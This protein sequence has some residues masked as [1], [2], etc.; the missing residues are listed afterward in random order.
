MATYQMQAPDGHTY[1]IDGPDGATDDQVRAEII[2]QNP[3]LGEPA[4]PPAAA[5]AQPKTPQQV[6]PQGTFASYA[7]KSSMFPQNQIPAGPVNIG[8]NLAATAQTGAHLATAGLASLGGGL[9]YLGTLAATQ[10]PSA[11][12]SVMQSTQNSLTYNPQNQISQQQLSGI[13]QG[14]AIPDR[15]GGSLGDK[16][17]EA[18]GSPF[19]ATT[20]RILPD[21]LAAFGPG[22]VAGAVGDATAGIAARALQNYRP[23]FTRTPEAQA[24]L[25]QGVDL[26]A[27]QMN[28][29]GVI[30]KLEQGAQRIP[31][32]GNIITSAR[33][34]ALQSF[35]RMI[36]QKAA[37]PGTTI[38]PADVNSMLD[39]AY[40]SYAPLY[41]KAKGIPVQPAIVSGNSSVPLA[42]AFASAAQDASIKAADSNRA[43]VGSWLQNKLTSLQTNPN[44]PMALDSAQLIDLRSDIRAQ[45]RKDSMSA[46]AGKNDEADLLRGA[47]NAITRSLE[48][49]LPPDALAALKTADQNYG[50]YKVI[51]KAVIKAKDNPNGFTPENLSQAIKESTS[52]GVYARG[53]GRFRSDAQAAK[54]SISPN[55]PVT[56]AILATIGVPAAA[57][58]A[59]PAVGAAAVGGALA[60]T[61]TQFGRNWA[62]GKT[63]VQLS[64][65]NLAQ[66]L[67]KRR[68]ATDIFNLGSG[69]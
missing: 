57:I 11:A 9:N 34:N 25:D 60:L 21:A 51:E 47:E 3:H 68:D 17:L 39:E 28:P 5:T 29:T 24:L 31:I 48:S 32:V 36:T 18:T 41:D 43:S 19:L 42:Q 1:T 55:E 49:Q 13:N 58:L 35:Q 7:P 52:P 40:Q 46:D 6:V 20:A 53:G 30:N 16:V 44:S 38:K 37:A 12:S 50:G 45:I 23:G 69:Q 14:L 8:A 62:A 54:S 2:R 67:G 63:G 15:I 65:Q 66:I 4:P 27:G 64:A 10:D 61:G 59:K 22:K 26:T 56:G 33:Q